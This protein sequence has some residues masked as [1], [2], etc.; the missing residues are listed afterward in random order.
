MS[1]HSFSVVDKLALAFDNDRLRSL[2]QGHLFSV[3]ARHRTEHNLRQFE[4]RFL[5][6]L[7]KKEQAVTAG[8]A[9]VPRMLLFVAFRRLKSTSDFF[10]TN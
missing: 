6:R 4:F 2:F 1:R 5:L 10:L 3:Q 9:L 7:N 8:V